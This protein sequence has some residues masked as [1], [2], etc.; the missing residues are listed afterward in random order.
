MNWINIR[1]L[2][3]NIDIMVLKYPNDERVD[4]LSLYHCLRVLLYLEMFHND[5]YHHSVLRNRILKHLLNRTIY[6]LT[7][8]LSPD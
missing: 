2:T 3:N 4:Y 5:A 6:S 8:S 1:M 7:I